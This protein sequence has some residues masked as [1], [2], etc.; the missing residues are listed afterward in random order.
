M[1][2]FLLGVLLI[3]ALA[4]AEPVKV[5]KPVV[6]DTTQTVLDELTKKYGEAP[7]FMGKRKDS[8]V[9]VFVNSKTTTWTVVQFNDK[10]A[11]GIDAGEGFQFRTDLIGKQVQG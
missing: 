6:C 8:M 3:P 10:I 11:C 5:D 9:A 4:F 2:K 7:I 1:H